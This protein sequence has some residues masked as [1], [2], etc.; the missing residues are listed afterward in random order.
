MIKKA[1]KMYLHEGCAKEYEKRHNELWDEMKEM[2]HQ[3]GGHNYS[4]FWMKKLIFYMDILRLKVKNFGQSQQ[5]QR[6]IES[7]G[8]IWLLLWKYMK[9]IVLYV[10][11]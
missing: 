2:I 7:G 6:L 11:T 4:I 1:F 5:I 9:I 3:Y 10:M 8:I